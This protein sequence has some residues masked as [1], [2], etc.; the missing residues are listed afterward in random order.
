MATRP[1][2]QPSPGSKGNNPGQITPLPD[3]NGSVDSGKPTRPT[4]PPVVPETVA[5]R[6]WWEAA[7]DYGQ[8]AAQKAGELIEMGEID[9]LNRAKGQ[10]LSG[11][12]W[13]VKAAGGGAVASAIGGVSKGAID[14]LAPTNVIDFIP[15]G[16]AVSAGKKALVNAGEKLLKKEGQHAAGK[17]AEK[18]A[19]KS[20]SK[21]ARR[22]D[23]GYNKKQKPRK[24]CGKHGKYKELP[25]EKGVLNADHVPS[26]AALKKAYEKKLMEA[27]AWD[28]MN[29]S[30]RESVL[31]H[32]YQNAPAISIPEDVHKEGRTFAGK[33]NRAQYNADAGDLKAA[34]KKDTDAIQKSM[35][36]KDHGCSEAY[37]KAVKE[38]EKTDFNKFFE[39]TMKENKIVQ[40][41]IKPK[42]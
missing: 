2:R 25:K 40:N 11:V 6:G 19:E 39:D 17:A 42:K 4:N 33:N 16:K 21:E 5:E 26:G 41:A 37:A 36:K 35:D 20:A 24:G 10:A 3:P 23:G 8:R 14:L 22:A 27:G 13:A 38:L 28:A 32:M 34:M 29:K 1:N 31:R 18:A 15:G 12:D 30:Q 7:K 9:V